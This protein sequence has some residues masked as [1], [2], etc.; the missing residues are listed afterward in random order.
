[1]YYAKILVLLLVCVNSKFSNNLLLGRFRKAIFK[2]YYV[3]LR[4]V[5][6][7]VCHFSV[8][9]KFERYDCKMSRKQF[10]YMQAFHR[11]FNHTGCPRGI[12]GIIVGISKVVRL[13]ED[14][15]RIEQ[16][17]QRFPIAFSNHLTTMLKKIK[18]EWRRYI[19]VQ[20]F[21]LL[22]FKSFFHEHVSVTS[23]MFVFYACTK[24]WN[25]SMVILKVFCGSII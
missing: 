24:L 7:Y 12:E 5:L 6:L 23:D 13:E 4:F 9:I 25:E 18:N 8:K 1:M 11:F 17:S 14:D 19:C 21:T 10:P 20:I 15:D 2:D 22:E 16:R 3:F